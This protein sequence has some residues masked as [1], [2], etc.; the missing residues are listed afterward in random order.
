MKTAKVEWGVICIFLLK[1]I[2]VP[3]Y[4]FDGSDPWYMETPCL[5]KT[6]LVKLQNVVAHADQRPLALHFLEP[7]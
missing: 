7:S 4:A 5:S 2:V 6:H 3:F 1:C